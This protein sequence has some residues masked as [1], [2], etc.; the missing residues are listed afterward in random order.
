MRTIN[1]QYTL[2]A[3]LFLLLFSACENEIDYKGS[4]PKPRLIMNAL[5]SADTIHNK[6]YLN[7][8]GN[9]GTPDIKD[10]VVEFYLN[11]VLKETLDYIPYNTEPYNT[12][13]YYL[14]TTPFTEDDNIRIE[15]TSS[16][17]ALKVYAEVVV[18]RRVFIQKIDSIY[19]PKANSNN[20]DGREGTMNLKI[21]LNDSPGVKNYYRLEVK[22]NYITHGFLYWE[23]CD[24]IQ[25][26][27]DY[28]FQSKSDMALNDGKPNSDISDGLASYI[29]NIYGA[30]DDS[31]FK[32]KS[33]TLN[34]DV[35]FDDSDSNYS[36]VDEVKYKCLEFVV[37][38]Q[39]I[40]EAQYHYLRV[41]N[42]L[43][44]DDYDPSMSQPV[45]IPSNVIGGLGF[46]GV[47]IGDSQKLIISES[48]GEED[49]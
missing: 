48:F 1:K 10:A 38:L 13:G 36:F 4:A 44:S 49:K 20:P 12:R 30:F 47:G 19:T 45:Q 11:D 40:T 21:A 14:V 32:D 22:K 18:P 9:Q 37:S 17:G 27:S 16:D 3:M 29:P 39:N 5:L 46:V 2:L 41:M 28:G 35:F 31:Y 23:E 25:C 26:R 6:V 15:A 33:Y 34:I 42:L 24:T 7:L 43:D 8:S